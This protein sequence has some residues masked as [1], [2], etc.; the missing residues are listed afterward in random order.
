[1]L[2]SKGEARRAG[3]ST[4]ATSPRYASALDRIAHYRGTA[5][6]AVAVVGA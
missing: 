6:S 3:Q 2:A 1:M 4:S 5:G